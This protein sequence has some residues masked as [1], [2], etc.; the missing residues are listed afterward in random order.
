MAV[1]AAVRQQSHQVQGL[2]VLFSVLHRIQQDLVPEKA[3]VPDGPCNPRQF[4]VNN[5]TGADIQVPHFGVAH[6]ALR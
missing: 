5:P 4:L 2:V 3:P 1:H 6:L